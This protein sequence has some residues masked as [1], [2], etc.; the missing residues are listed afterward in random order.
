MP[1]SQFISQERHILHFVTD[2][3]ESIMPVYNCFTLY[4]KDP[5]LQVIVCPWATLRASLSLSL[6][7][8]KLEIVIIFNCTK[9]LDQTTAQ[10]RAWHRA[11]R[12]K[13]SS[14]SSTQGDRK[15]GSR[16]LVKL[17]TGQQPGYPH[18]LRSP[19]VCPAS[20]FILYSTCL[21]RCSNSIETVQ[22]QGP[23]WWCSG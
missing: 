16:L 8:S 18:V 3:N 19:R 5:C 4:L 22:P 6:P 2:G 23:A 21:Q 1:K 14:G 13:G 10:A 17:I 7:G 9:F 11:S 15:R 20:L 12:A